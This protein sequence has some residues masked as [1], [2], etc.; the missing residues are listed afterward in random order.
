MTLWLGFI[1]QW[2]HG[3]ILACLDSPSPGDVQ[4]IA[5]NGGYNTMPA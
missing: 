4:E 5:G 2:Q 1:V 3:L